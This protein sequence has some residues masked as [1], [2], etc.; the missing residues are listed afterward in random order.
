[1][2]ISN[3]VLVTLTIIFFITSSINIFLIFQSDIA[4]GKV[5]GL[6]RLIVQVYPPYVPPSGGGGGGGAPGGV[7]KPAPT[8]CEERWQCSDWWPQCENGNQTRVCVDTNHCGT[9]DYEPGLIRGCKECVENWSC[10]NWSECM[11]AQQKRNCTDLNECGTLI[12]NPEKIR[13]CVPLSE[14]ALECIPQWQ[15]SNWGQCDMKINVESVLR[16]DVPNFADLLQQRN[17]RDI[18]GCRENSTEKRTCTLDV[19]VIIDKYILNNRKIWDIFSTVSELKGTRGT[20][21]NKVAQI[22]LF[23]DKIDIYLD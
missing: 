20:S 3:N 17:C 21:V 6:V 4:T 19:Q 11:G 22:I 5:T 8:V 12:N 23:E 1:M 10:S 14:E 9:Y 15:C 16:S 18:N 2:K 13:N 7:E